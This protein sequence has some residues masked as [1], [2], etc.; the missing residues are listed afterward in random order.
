MY[1]VI[2]V[3]RGEKAGF[4]GRALLLEGKKI[5]E[6]PAFRVIMAPNNARANFQVI[7]DL[8]KRKPQPDLDIIYS[9]DRTVVGFLNEGITASGALYDLMEKLLLLIPEGCIVRLGALK[10]SGLP[11]GHTR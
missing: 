2:E 11:V 1:A 10:N 5:I 4:L 8:L 6:E 7:T 9:S 3:K